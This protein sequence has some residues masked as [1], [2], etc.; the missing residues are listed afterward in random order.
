MARAHARP[1]TSLLGRRERATRPAL[2][3]RR[4]TARG[5]SRASPS[6]SRPLVA[7]NRSTL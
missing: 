6:D 7:A 4:R 5:Y 1:G 2:G 3:R